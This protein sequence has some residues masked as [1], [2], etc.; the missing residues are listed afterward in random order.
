MGYRKYDP[1]VKKMIIETGNRNLFPE[2]NIPRTTIN[3]WLQYSKEKVT[4][5]TN[6]IYEQ[7]IRVLKKDNFEQKAKS[8]LAKKCLE[9]LLSELGGYD[10]KSKENRKF[11][12]ETIESLKGLQ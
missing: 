3:Y 7:T 2:L 1:M 9:K 11:V 8:L 6:H 4:S 12:V 5:K 10:K